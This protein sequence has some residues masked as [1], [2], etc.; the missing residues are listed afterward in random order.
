MSE[1]DTKGSSV[2]LKFRMKPSRAELLEN[3]AKVEAAGNISSLLRDLAERKI[4][5]EFPS[6]ALPEYTALAS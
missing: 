3:I 2:I 4:A 6:H 1:R 5:A